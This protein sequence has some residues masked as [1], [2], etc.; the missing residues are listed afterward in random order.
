V[1]CFATRFVAGERSCAVVYNSGAFFS[2][3]VKEANGI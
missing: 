1:I 2:R 3:N